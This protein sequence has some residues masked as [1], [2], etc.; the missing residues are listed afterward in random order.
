ME[1][2]AVPAYGVR[3]DR[4]RIRFENLHSV[5]FFINEL[6]QVYQFKVWGNALTSMFVLVKEDSEIVDKLRVG[7]VFSMKYHDGD[8]TT[9]L[10]T[11]IKYL[12]KVDQGRFK[13]HYI[14]GLSLLA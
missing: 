1:Q 3:L 5:E 6:N 4:R 11:A 2:T 13:G 9:D 14:A 10:D 7:K 8:A 12:T